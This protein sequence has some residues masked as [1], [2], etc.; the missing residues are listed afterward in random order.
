LENKLPDGALLSKLDDLLGGLRGLEA[1]IGEVVVMGFNVFIG[2]KE[3]LLGAGVSPELRFEGKWT[4]PCS[5]G[6]QDERASLGGLPGAAGGLAAAV[7]ERGE[8]GIFVGSS[9]SR[10]AAR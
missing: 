10:I 7:G 5:D 4:V 2:F 1:R 8:V 6:G 9:K 3:G